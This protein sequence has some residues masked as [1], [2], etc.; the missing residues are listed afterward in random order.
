MMFTR[1]IELFSFVICAYITLL[2]AERLSR[3]R[4]ETVF[5]VIKA[6]MVVVA[7][8][9]PCLIYVHADK[10]LVSQQF[11]TILDVS[12][13]DMGGVVDIKV[14]DEE[15]CQSNVETIVTSG[16]QWIFKTFYS[17][18]PYVN[19]LQPNAKENNLICK[20]Y[21]S[22][23]KEYIL[24]YENHEEFTSILNSYRLMREIKD[25]I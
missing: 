15:G 20:Q 6:G 14:Q 8:A 13:S 4:M 12:E 22:G 2:A 17:G 18:T 24:E 21:E 11:Y 3:G 25:G 16:P 5:R 10:K 23:R 7:I 1:V 19:E 9:G